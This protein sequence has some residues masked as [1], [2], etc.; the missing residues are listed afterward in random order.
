MTDPTRLDIAAAAA[1][2]RAGELTASALLQAYLERIDRHDRRLNAF[3][4]VTARAAETQ[5]QAADAR[6]RAG[7]PLSPLDGIPIALKD[8]IDVAGVVTT[9]GMR[10]EVVAQEDA[11]VAH[12]LRAAGAVLLGKLNMHEGALGGTTDNPHH[13]RAHNPWAHDHT[14]GGSSG[15][16]GAAV[17]AR[18]CAAALGTDTLGSVRLPAH[19]CGVCGLKATTGLI[20]TRG[21][22]PLSYALDHVGPLTRT[23]R[24]LAAMTAVMAGPDPVS[25]ESV[26]PPDGWSAGA[27]SPQSPAGLRI[28]VLRNFDAEA[29]DEAVREAFAAA[30]ARLRRLGAE[31]VEV[32]LDGYAPTPMRLAGVLISEAEAAFALDDELKATPDMASDA[33]KQMVAF[34][35]DA[36]AWKLVRAQRRAAEAGAAGRR[37]FDEVDLLVSPTA[38]QVAFRFDAGARDDQADF[39]ALA[40][41]ARAP[42]V[43]VPSGFTADGLPLGLQLIAPPFAEARLLGAAAAFEADAAL[44]LAPPAYP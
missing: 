42:A 31:V 44:D 5:A 32:A 23:V 24:D 39:T 29:M 20:S 33:F 21:V 22:M 30:L 7:R 17:A 13:G 35:R 8:N 28:G 40:N 16:S 26:A 34:G 3:I 1:A 41:Y 18:L 14:P 43:S 19:Y 38:P 6:L 2:M 36:P 9:N 37:L 10:R 11:P 25:P 4:T 27:G 15:G 12:R